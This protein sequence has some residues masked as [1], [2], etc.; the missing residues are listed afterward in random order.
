LRE[1]VRTKVLVYCQHFDLEHIVWHAQCACGI[2]LGT[3]KLA[4]RSRIMFT[5]LQFV[6]ITSEFVL[7][8]F[9][10]SYLAQVECRWGEWIVGFGRNGLVGNLLT[11]IGFSHLF[12]WTLNGI[13]VR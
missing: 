11:S 6:A 3:I 9:H 2:R 12:G 4:Q 8:Q 1:V 5:F 13:E 7:T 10:L